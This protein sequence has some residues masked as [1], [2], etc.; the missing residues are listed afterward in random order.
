[1]PELR[2]LMTGLVIGESPRWHQDR[3]WFSHWGAEEII[4]VDVEGNSEVAAPG[5]PGLGWSIDWLPDGRLL[6]TG[7]QLLRREADGSMV[8]HADLSRV[9]DGWNEIVVDGGLSNRRVWAEGLAPDGICVDGEGAVWTSTGANDCV[10]VGEGGEILQRIEL[11][12]SLFACM[13]GGNDR[14]TLFML[15]VEWRTQESV[16]DNLIRLTNGPHTGQVLA[17][18]ARAPGAG[19]P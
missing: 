2:T 17:A 11:D 7:Q 19:W 10:R 18:P 13:L 14:T 6:V 15:A 16:P 3:L 1:M 5:P 12:R 8:T 9:S 4:A